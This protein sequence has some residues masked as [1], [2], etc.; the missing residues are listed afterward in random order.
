MVQSSL[1]QDLLS[2]FVSS[3]PDVQG[4][5]LVSLDGL[6]IIS[7]LSVQMDEETMAAMS[8]AM[9]SLGERM[10]TEVALGVM[11]RFLSSLTRFLKRQCLWRQ[12]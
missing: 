4:S 6:P 8:A 7:V 12:G 9:L 11:K 10:G 1:L 2:N 3:T 5:A